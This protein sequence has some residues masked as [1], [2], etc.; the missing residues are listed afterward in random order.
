MHLLLQTPTSYNTP[1]TALVIGNGIAGISVAI[2]LAKRGIQ[3]TLLEQHPYAGLAASGNLAGA[4]LP[5]MQANWSNISKF[6]YHAYHYALSFYQTHHKTILSEATGALML[7][8]ND[9]EHERQEKM[10][11]YQENIASMLT[12]VDKKQASEIAGYPLESSGL[13]FPNTRWIHAPSAMEIQHDLIEK[14]FNQEALSLFFNGS[15]WILQ[16]ENK[17]YQAEAVILTNGQNA[18]Q[19]KY[20]QYL[21]LA[22]KR[23]QISYAYI[24]QQSMLKTIVS[25]GSYMIP[26]YA[27]WYCL[28]A[29]CAPGLIYPFMR[30]EDHKKNIQAMQVFL[31]DLIKQIDQDRLYGRV[32][33]RVTS[34]DHLPL[35]GAVPI[36]QQVVKQLKRIKKY[37]S[38]SEINNLYYPNLYMSLGHGSR[39]LLTA[40][41]AGEIIAAQINQEPLPITSEVLTIIQPLRFYLRQLKKLSAAAFKKHYLY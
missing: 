38:S 10:R 15:S 31:P 35:I 4:V 40:P 22:I 41:I 18:L 14:V 20:S 27:H 3:V 33:Y 16:T 37:Y 13:Y 11:Q 28:G 26:L 5:L 7:A 24:P 36:F 39:G 30:L 8:F 23:G 6:F 21:G 9:K 1:K 29:T 32:A 12:F 17:I 19:W 2:S 34:M 25:A